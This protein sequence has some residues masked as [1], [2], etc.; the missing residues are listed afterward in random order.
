LVG[1]NFFSFEYRRAA[2]SFILLLHL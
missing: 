1:L 2:F